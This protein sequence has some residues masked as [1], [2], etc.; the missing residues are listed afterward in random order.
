MMTCEYVRLE[1]LQVGYELIEG[2]LNQ[3][4]TRIECPDFTC[5]YGCILKYRNV[6]V[7]DSPDCMVYDCLLTELCRLADLLVCLGVEFHLSQ[8]SFQ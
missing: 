1:L 3:L 6:D 8:H 4:K 5:P 2:E 7:L